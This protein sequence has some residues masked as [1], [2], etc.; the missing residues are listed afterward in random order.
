MLS[1]QR[2]AFSLSES[3]GGGSGWPSVKLAQQAGHSTSDCLTG[4]LRLP[5]LPSS[6]AI[7]LGSGPAGGPP[8]RPLSAPH[9]RRKASDLS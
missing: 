3:R 4:C 2:S 8:L 1:E 5:L 7:L 9:R 6:A